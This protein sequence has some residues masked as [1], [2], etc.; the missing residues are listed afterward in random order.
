ML[1]LDETAIVGVNSDEI[2]EAGE[3]IDAYGERECGIRIDEE[4]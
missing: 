2:T 3:R 4:S 1:A